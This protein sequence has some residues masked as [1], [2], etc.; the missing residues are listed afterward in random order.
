MWIKREDCHDVTEA[1]WHSGTLSTTP[2]GVASNFQQCA[3]ALASWNQNVVG[4]I[5]KKIAGKRRTLNAIT[6]ADKLGVRG[7][8]IN[9]LRGE[10]NDLLDSE[11]IIW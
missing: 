5:P 4:N 10:I 1:A 2:E 6:N 7:A 3:S 9:Q 11:K 8:E